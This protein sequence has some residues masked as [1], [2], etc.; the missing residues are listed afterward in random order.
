MRLTFKHAIVAGFISINILFANSSILCADDIKP[1][2]SADRQGN[3]YRD[4]VKRVLPA[5]VSIESYVQSGPTTRD[6]AREQRIPDELR[7][8][9][10]I[11]SEHLTRQSD[12]GSREARLGAASGFIVDSS[13]VIV[14][15]NHVVEGADLVTVRLKDGRI[16][17]SR[18]IATDEKTDLAIV[19]IAAGEALPSLQ[20]DSSA[21]MEIGDRVLAV[22]APFGLHGSVTTG[23]VSGK[24]RRIQL[25]MYE[26]FIQTDAAI[27]PGNSGGP[28]VN[29]NGKVIG[30]NSV[31]ETETG[32]FQGIGLAISSNLARGI[33]EQLTATGIVKR[34]YLGILAKSLTPEMAR[35]IGRHGVLAS[36]VLQASP[37]AK[38]GLR[39][40][41]VI[42]LLD[43]K[44]INTPT[45]LS[46]IVAA[47]PVGSRIQITVWREGKS[48]ILPAM[49]EERQSGARD[50]T[51]PIPAQSS[52]RIYL[53]SLG[54]AIA[55]LS[56]TTAAKL[57]LPENSTGALIVELDPNGPAADIG[58]DSG[59]AILKVDGMEVRSAESARKAIAAGFL[60]RG[61]LLQV[62][63]PN[64][65]VSLIL[66]RNSNN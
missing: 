54:M 19:R 35:R 29:M 39:E 15:N 30:V 27:N 10:N 23:I 64:E 8:F 11:P 66:L 56:S 33:V 58:L 52:Q 16:F 48:L 45:D 37:A 21:D 26:D 43:D 1:A 7:Q 4:V 49:I 3:S 42:T 53:K 25:N 17:S 61:I 59:S 65:G 34:G 63:T 55:D 31:I 36:K 14:T 40:G 47:R 41:D 20:W 12:S 22:G 62:F 18:N 44:S 6:A 2:V 38:A 57:G 5:V 32:A 50:G 46:F 24:E 51:A 9:F 13:G 60:E 28:L